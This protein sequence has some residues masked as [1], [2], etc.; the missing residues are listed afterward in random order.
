MQERLGRHIQHLLKF[1]RD[2]YDPLQFNAVVADINRPLLINAGRFACSHSHIYMLR[3]MPSP[4][5]TF[6]GLLLYNGSLGMSNQLVTN[7][8]NGGYVI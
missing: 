1:G 5:S 6:M 8:R 4:T 7:H 3:N 2:V